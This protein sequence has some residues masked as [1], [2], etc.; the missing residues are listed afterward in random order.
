VGVITDQVHPFV[1]ACAARDARAA[2]F[3]LGG[4]AVIKAGETLNPPPRQNPDDP[5]NTFSY[6]ACHGYLFRHPE[7]VP[8][9]FYE[10]VQRATYLNFAARLLMLKVAAIFKAGAI[11]RAFFVDSD[12]KAEEN[13]LENCNRGGMSLDNFMAELVFPWPEV[14]GGC[15]I[16]VDRPPAPIDPKTGEVLRPKSLAQQQEWGLAP[17]VSFFRKSDIMD[18]RVDASGNL[19][20]LKLR[21]WIPSD[22]ALNQERTAESTK[23]IV[24]WTRQ[25]WTR[26]GVDA[27]GLEVVVA[28]Q[29]HGLHEIPFVYV[30]SRRIDHMQGVSR[31]ADVWDLIWRLYNL[32]SEIEEDVRLSA[33]S[34]ACISGQPAPG[35]TLAFGSTR[36]IGVPLDAKFAPTLLETNGQPYRILIQERNSL[37]KQLFDLMLVRQVGA[38]ADETSGVSKAWDYLPTNQDLSTLAD[39]LEWAEQRV[40]YFRALWEADGDT[41]VARERMTQVSYPNDFNVQTMSER[42]NDLTLVSQAVP[43][44]PTYRVE[45]ERLF[46]YA[47]PEYPMF[48]EEKKLAIEA[49]FDLRIKA[50]SERAKIAPVVQEDESGSAEMPGPDTEEIMAESQEA[51]TALA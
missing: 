1:S 25:G 41:R 32:E 23:R 24:I 48:S 8:L 5:Q 7:E 21:E 17:F 28:S 22:I 36:F 51:A 3:Y 30:P 27:Q 9:H 43:N 37:L 2:D 18:W 50:M 4:D 31:I 38:G 15:G 11:N 34:T 49:D 16:L 35:T 14:E 20:E 44:S 33:V 39:R 12:E 46:V 42:A 10:R 40:H 45:K 29:I 13:F 19:L 47:D 26:Y 6:A